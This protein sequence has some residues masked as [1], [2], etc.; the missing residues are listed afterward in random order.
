M[1]RIE[2][3]QAR[4]V[5]DSRG[6][7]TVE[8]E[9]ACAGARPGRSIVPSG[10]STGRFEAVELRDGDPSRLDGTGVRQAVGNVNGQIARALIGR[11]AADQQAIDRVLIELDGTENKSRLGAN[12]VL[13]ASLAV[14]SAAAE[15]RHLPLVLHLRDVWRRVP[16]SSDVSRAPDRRQGAGQP[17]SAGSVPVLGE[18]MC[19]PLPMVNMISGGLHAGRNLDVQDVLILPVG[20]EAYRQALDWIVAVYRRLGGLL[21]QRGY[22]AALIGDEGGYGPKLNS[23]R[24]ALEIVVAA[25]EAAGLRPGDDVALG[26]DVAATHFHRDAAYRLAK[27]GGQ[28]LSAAEMVDLLAEW[29]AAFPILSIEDGLAEEDWDGWKLLTE[30]LG[31]QVQLVGDDLFVT[32]RRRLERGMAVGAANAV[33]IKPNQI[34]TVWETLETLRLALD[35]GYLPV[36][37]ARSGETEDATIADLAVATGAGQIK[38]GAVARSERLAKYNQLLRLEEALSGSAGYLGGRIFKAFR[39][40]R[41]VLRGA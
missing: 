29:A 10:A 31:E 4:E 22:E 7:P 28:P 38:I 8:V 26:L 40:G 25:I 21:A 3:V 37:S 33:L 27:A 39:A 35:G 17:A 16:Q 20:A 19:L 18:D 24:E 41:P 34:G 6:K 2:R 11:D 36:V 14:A 12:A 1:T 13:G 15:A 30:R 23:N 32:N 5:F 9:V